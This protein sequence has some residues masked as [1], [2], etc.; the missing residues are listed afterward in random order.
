MRVIWCKGISI[1]AC[2]YG[3]A[4]GTIEFYVAIFYFPLGSSRISP[5]RKSP[6]SIRAIVFHQDSLQW[7]MDTIEERGVRNVLKPSLGN[8]DAGV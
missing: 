2:G 4:E 7:R 8:F 1:D 3:L 5:M 6:Y